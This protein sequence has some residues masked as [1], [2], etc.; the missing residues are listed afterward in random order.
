MVVEGGSGH[1]VLQSA[2]G[3]PAVLVAWLEPQDQWG[4]HRTVPKYGL[5]HSSWFVASSLVLGLES[6]SYLI[7]SYFKFP[8]EEPQSQAFSRLST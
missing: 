5:G 7:M 1:S 4:P 8:A 2:L 3:T 6:N